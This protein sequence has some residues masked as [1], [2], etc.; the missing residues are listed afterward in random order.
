MM[1]G[2]EY[3]VDEMNKRNSELLVD[4]HNE[5]L[6]VM[7][8]L[9]LDAGFSVTLT[10][11][12]FSNYQWIADFS[13]FKPYP[14]MNVLHH[15]GPFVSIYKREHSS[16]LDWQ[17]EHENTLIKKYLPMFTFLKASFPVMRDSIYQGGGYLLISESFQSLD[18]FLSPYSHLYYLRELSSFN[19]EGNAF[20]SIS[21]NTTHVPIRLQ[22]PEYEP[23]STMT[24][25]TTPYDMIEGIREI[26][27]LH[28][29]VNAAALKRIGFWFDQLREEGVYDNTRIVIVSD[30]GRSL[31]SEGMADFIKNRYVYNGF[32]PLLLMKD[33]D[34]TGTL[35]EDDTFMTN[36]DAPLFAI[37]DLTSPINPFTGKNMYDQIKKDRVNVYNGPFDPR[38]IKGTKHQPYLDRSFSIG[39]DI[40]VE[41]NWGPVEIEGANR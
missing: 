26:D 22:T 19:M 39:E 13:P 17:L 29:Y 6:L 30:H 5:S 31:Y 24:N 12:P 38:T 1:G 8:K 18:S 25:S 14:E 7:P 3:T 33:F 15:E 41:V 28:Y 10:D 27:I 40:H 20:I 36:A 23:R 32:V 4:K 2:Y 37:R 34:A 35:I 16:H 21:N 11:P 9:F